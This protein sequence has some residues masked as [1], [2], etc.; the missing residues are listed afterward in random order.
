[1]RPSRSGTLTLTGVRKCGVF[2]ASTSSRTPCGLTNTPRR[3]SRRLSTRP[4]ITSCPP[5]IDC[6]STHGNILQ[7]LPRTTN[8][9]NIGT[10]TTPLEVLMTNIINLTPHPV[11]LV[12]AN[13]DEVVIQPEENPVRIPAET[14]PAGEINNIPVV[15]ERLGN[16]DDV[17]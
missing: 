14:K 17:L 3:S 7:H 4:R 15:E 16:A 6:E 8:P 10:A 11:T 9:A 5:G 2:T 13:G 12:T 1:W